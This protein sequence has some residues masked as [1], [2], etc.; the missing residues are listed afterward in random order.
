MEDARGRL[1]AAVV[2]LQQHWREETASEQSSGLHQLRGEWRL[3]APT[4]GQEGA[5][6]WP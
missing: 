5:A 6:P 2:M 1:R 3:E 4:Q